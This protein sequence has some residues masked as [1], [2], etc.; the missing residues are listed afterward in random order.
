MSGDLDVILVVIRRAAAITS[1]EL[2]SAPSSLEFLA[3][4]T[5]QRHRKHF[6]VLELRSAFEFL[7]VKNKSLLLI[8]VV[9]L[10]TSVLGKTGKQTRVIISQAYREFSVVYVLQEL[11]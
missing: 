5:L 1:L 2:N 3:R 9:V 10:D 4:L 7:Y 11:L 6:L 8:R